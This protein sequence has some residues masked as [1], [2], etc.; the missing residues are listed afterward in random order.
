MVDPYP[1]QWAAIKAILGEFD[2]GIPSTLLVLPTGTGKTVTSAFVAKDVIDRGGRVL[3]LAHREELLEGAANDYA[4]LEIETV[5]EKSSSHARPDFTRGNGD[6]IFPDDPKC[7]LGSTGT[8]QGD[9]LGRWPQGHFDLIITDEGH[10]GVA[11]TYKKRIE[12]LKPKWHLG[13]TATWERGDDRRIVGKGRPFETLAYEYHMDE[14]VDQGY[15]ARVL[16]KMLPCSVDL[17]ELRPKAGD[18]AKEDLAKKIEPHVKEIVETMG[19]HLEKRRSLVFLPTIALSEIF[20]SA[21][22]SWGIPSQSLSGEDGDR[23]EVVADFR[24]GKFRLL[25][26]AMLFTEGT[27]FPFVDAVGILRATRSAGL[28][29]QMVGR[30]TR[31][32][33]GRKQ[34]C[35]IYGINWKTFDHKLVNP[36]QI[37]DHDGVEEETRQIGKLLADMDAKEGKEIDLLDIMKR[38]E[39]RRQKR[40]R[41]R[42]QI[43]RNKEREATRA[44]TV[45]PLAFETGPTHAP[46]GEWNRSEAMTSVMA[47]PKQTEC[48]IRMGFNAAAV[49]SWTKARASGVIGEQMR[50]REQ[51]LASYK[52][53]QYLKSLGCYEA[54][55]LT[56]AE[57]GAEISRRKSLSLERGQNEA[58]KDQ[59]PTHAADRV[60]TPPWETLSA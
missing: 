53:V 52:Q 30:A 20:A 17:R 35:H 43:E 27:N 25:C 1:Y 16:F 48:L 5:L 31:T 19:P 60:Q 11:D 58:S 21:F 54:S 55:R 24:A 44:K 12:H 34:D 36:V 50:R 7:V 49:K 22:D 38:A 23:S 47:T 2:R 42:L 41:R 6:S 33:G 51:G 28:F 26:N 18:W 9:R 14:A 8:L 46:R 59:G 57:A 29:K 40:V 39:E 3:F 15:L 45:D 10:H 32:D 56:F 4:A 37:F 13:M